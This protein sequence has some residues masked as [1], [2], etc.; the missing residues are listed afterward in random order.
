MSR[1]G[2]DRRGWPAS[3]SHH[4]SLSRR[5]PHNQTAITRVSK[6]TPTPGLQF[7]P[8]FGLPRG[9]KPGQDGANEEKNQTQRLH[10]KHRQ[11]VLEV[12]RPVLLRYTAAEREP[13][14][15]ERDWRPGPI[16]HPKSRLMHHQ[17]KTGQG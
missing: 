14:V 15:A 13:Q 12:P 1:A 8:V 4:Y 11:N 5:R 6:T 2:R 7:G 17:R 10:Q 9:P 3:P 16:V